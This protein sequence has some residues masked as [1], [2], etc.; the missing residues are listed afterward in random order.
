MVA[1]QA[2]VAPDSKPSAKTVTTE[3][4]GNAQGVPKPEPRG[5]K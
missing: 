1:D 2:R 3:D 5:F 4:V